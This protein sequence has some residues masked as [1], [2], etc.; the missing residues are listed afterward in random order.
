MMRAHS[1]IIA[2][3]DFG[4][5]D[6]MPQL[7]DQLYARRL[8]R[9]RERALERGYDAVVIYADREHSA[10]LAWLSGFDPRFEEAI[11]ILSPADEPLL[12]TGIECVGVAR[13]AP[14]Q[15]RV[16]LAPDLSLAGQPRPVGRTLEAI[17][18]AEGI[19]RGSRVG[20][21]GWKALPDR[22]WLET[23]SF[24]VD[25][26]RSAVG[27]DGLVENAGDLFSDPETGLRA[28]NEPE[29]LALME[30]AACHTS[31]GVKR[32][33]FGLRPGMTEQDA[34][35]LLQWPG[36]PM[37]CHMM[38]SSGERATFGLLSPTDRVI[39]RGDRFTVAY[40][41]WGAL[42]CRAG[43]VA[44]DADDLPAGIRDYESKLVAPYFEAVA[45]WLEALHVGQTGGALQAIIDEQLA[46]PFFGIFL[47]PGHLI[48]LEEWLHSP[49]APA[50]GARLRSG[51]VIESD[52]IPATGTEYFTTNVE[53]PF[54]LADET[55]RAELA[56][57]YP[58]MWARIEARRA[59]MHDELGI[60]LHPDALPFSNL[61][62]YLA[63]FLLRPER[64][65]T[66]RA[67]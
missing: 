41:L 15:M 34:V 67:G 53:S 52:V 54:A 31:E 55:L 20:V 24:M 26:L 43:F 48:S 33:L 11:L 39:E 59:F 37:S 19:G 44:G 10:N 32:L 1:E 25:A 8:G 60:E 12:L 38:L 36:F 47:T 27:A 30:Y 50:S 22:G 29:Q 9:L 57:R 28:V 42:D 13:R 61:P 17:L 62:A 40:G 64:A 3:P 35:R 63:P 2:L 51:A 16:E 14:L 45:R 58:Q 46:D 56:A 4:L 7:P 18:A 21:A 23:P 5:P 65:M 49:I 66:R 6:A